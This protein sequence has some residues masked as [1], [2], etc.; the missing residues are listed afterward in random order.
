[1]SNDDAETGLADEALASL[2]VFSQTRSAEELTEA[3][4]VT[5]DEA[6]NKGELNK[7]G[8]P[9]ETTAICFRSQIPADR[10]PSEH[11]G[12]LL[13]RLEPLQ[14]KLTAQIDAGDSVRLKLAVFADTD[15]PM[16]SLATE[17]IQRVAALGVELDFDIYEV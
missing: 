3:L 2:I 8:R 10:S 4:G 14:G 13:T 7:R 12:S 9:Y 1:M 15:N 6:W 16:F 5:P 17:T 11:L